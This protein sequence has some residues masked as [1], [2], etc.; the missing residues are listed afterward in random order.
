VRNT[1]LAYALIATLCTL[2]GVTNFAAAQGT[3]PPNGTNVALIDINKVFEKHAEFQ[4][5][6]KGLGERFKNLEKTVKTEQGK[7]LKMKDALENFTP[8]TPQYKEKEAELAKTESEVRVSAGLEQ[9]SLAEEEAKIYYE[10]YREIEQATADFA[11]QKKIGLVLRH[12][13]AEMKPEDPNSVR[14]GLSRTVIYQKG[15]DITELIIAQLNRDAR[16]TTK[17]A[18]EDG[19]KVATPPGKGKKAG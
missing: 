3:A 16:P 11:M 15:L 2:L 12:T 7:L 13:N 19:T 8:G 10:T 6:F 4:E 17:K 5:R 14:M 18:T 9:K 1:R